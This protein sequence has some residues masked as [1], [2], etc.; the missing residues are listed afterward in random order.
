ME[1]EQF[2]SFICIQKGKRYA[3]LELANQYLYNKMGVEA[4]E[5]ETV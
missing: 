4:K 3:I 2:T 5:K 1:Q